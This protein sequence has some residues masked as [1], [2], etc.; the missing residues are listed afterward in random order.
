M[1]E[2]IASFERHPAFVRGADRARQRAELNKIRAVLPLTADVAAAWV[3]TAMLDER[4]VLPALRALDEMPQ[5][6]RITVFSQS[7]VAA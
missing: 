6:T 4:A 3:W 5:Q 2:T 7:R 1:K